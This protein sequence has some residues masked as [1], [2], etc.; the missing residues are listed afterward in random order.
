MLTLLSGRKSAGVQLGRGYTQTIAQLG[1]KTQANFESK[2]ASPD[3]PVPELQYSDR[4][5]ALLNRF[6]VAYG[7]L[8]EASAKVRAQFGTPENIAAFNRLRTDYLALKSIK[9]PAMRRDAETALLLNMRNLLAPVTEKIDAA[10]ERESSK[11][12]DVYVAFPRPVQRFLPLKVR[13]DTQAPARPRFDLG[14]SLPS[15]ALNPGGILFAGDTEL[16]PM[17]DRIL[18]GNYSDAIGPAPVA[19]GLSLTSIIRGPTEG[20]AAL[21][22]WFEGKDASLSSTITQVSK[23]LA[24]TRSAVPPKGQASNADPD[25]TERLQSLLA[26]YTN[27]RN[28]VRQSLAAVRSVSGANTWYHTL[29]NLKRSVTSDPKF[30]LLGED[31][32]ANP[33]LGQ[34]LTQGWI[35]PDQAPSAA[36]AQGKKAD[37]DKSGFD[38]AFIETMIRFGFD[39]GVAWGEDV[40]GATEDPQH[41][42]LTEGFDNVVDPAPA[43]L[44][45]AAARQQ[46][47]RAKAA[48]KARAG[49]QQG[50]TNTG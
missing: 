7:E 43:Q 30:V 45:A 18:E 13:L 46:A 27:Q 33:S 8:V 34:V 32:V 3:A 9:D 2:Q 38:I 47:E 16:D 31:T 14:G 42:Q 39:F 36:A 49:E 6:V 22:A 26:K 1:R 10:I 21:A 29:L 40:L 50:K 44:N 37:R 35:N 25:R 20:R 28:I 17:L 5:Q 12:G 15:G 41:F 23:A 19:R 24:P 11:G 4:E 48:P